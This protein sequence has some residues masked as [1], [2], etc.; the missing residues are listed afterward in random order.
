MHAVI[1][2]FNNLQLR[3]WNPRSDILGLFRWANP[4]ALTHNNQSFRRDQWKLV[5]IIE[6]FLLLG[7]EVIF[8]RSALFCLE[9]EK[10][11]LWDFA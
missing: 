3:S 6:E 4:I 8:A 10:N 1:G 2:I 5:P 7:I 9:V 11:S